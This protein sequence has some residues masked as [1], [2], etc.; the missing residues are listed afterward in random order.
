MD[1]F[2]EESKSLEC[3]WKEYVPLKTYFIIQAI[4]WK[5]QVAILFSVFL[6]ESPKLEPYE[7]TPQ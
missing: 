7:D 4:G 2:K 1:I 5:V 6:P 3:S